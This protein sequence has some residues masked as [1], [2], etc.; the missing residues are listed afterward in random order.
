MQRGLYCQPNRAKKQV[1]QQFYYSF[2]S[3]INFEPERLVGGTPEADTFKWLLKISTL[4]R[5]Q[6][7]ELE[8][9]VVPI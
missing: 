2:S 3:S 1:N 7:Q 4:L 6:Q 8:A 9:G 5:R